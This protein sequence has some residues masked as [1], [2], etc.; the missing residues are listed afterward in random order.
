MISPDDIARCADGA[1][2]SKS[3]QNTRS[4]PTYTLPYSQA[5]LYTPK[6]FKPSSSLKGRRKLATLLR[7]KPRVLIYL[8]CSTNTSRDSSVGIATRLWA[9]RSG[10]QVS[11]PGG[12]WEF[13]FYPMGTRG[14]KCWSFKWYILYRTWCAHL[15]QWFSNYSDS[16]DR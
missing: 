7:G 4:C 6:V 1:L 10:F 11:I 8:Q 3:Q 5:M 16:R 13:F 2:W 12:G 9:G 14:P 15:M